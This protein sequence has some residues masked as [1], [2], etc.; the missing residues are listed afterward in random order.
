MK[1]NRRRILGAL[2]ALPAVAAA[3][4]TYA[5]KIEP[6][7]VEH[8]KLP[9]PIKNLP[10]TLVGRTLVQI[11]D[12]HIG[13]RVD[14]TFL[15]DA[16]TEVKALNPDFVVYTGDFITHRSDEQFGQL[17][18]ILAQAPYGR[19]GTAAILGNHDYGQDWRRPDADIADIV[20]AI[21]SDAGITLLRNERTSIAG[22]TIAGIDDLLS[23]NFFPSA[24]LS[25][26]DAADANLVL[27][28]NPD[29]VDLP[30]WHGY[31]GW[32]LSGHTHGG[33]VKLPFLPPPAL[34][35]ENELYSSGRFDLVDG[36]ILYINRALG[37]AIPL[38]FNVRPEVTI[39][40]LE[41]A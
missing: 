33:Q 10:A 35:V 6:Y 22:L 39:F 40:T 14:Q 18:T 9:M 25:Q 15:V 7:W 34:P 37:H 2:V 3:L 4:G 5:I 13:D 38:R 36:R 31:D 24:V 17:Q 11:S 12:I 41:S 27:C 28:H 29:V 30:V 23:P 8:V 16:L 20:S 19:L 21:I 26:L 1:T 32:I